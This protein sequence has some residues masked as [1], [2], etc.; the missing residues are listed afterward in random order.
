M[1]ILVTHF[2]NADFESSVDNLI[3]VICK[4]KIRITAGLSSLCLNNLHAAHRHVS[5]SL[6]RVL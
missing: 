2:L 3:K 1:S 4:N 5:V 6:C